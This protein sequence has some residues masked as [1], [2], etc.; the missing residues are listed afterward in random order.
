MAF[1]SIR[2]NRDC[3]QVIPNRTL[4]VLKN[5]LRRYR[6]LISAGAA[7]PQL[8]GREGINLET[9][10]FWAIRFTMIVAPSDRDELG[11][12]FLIRHARNGAQRERPCCCGEEEVLRHHQIRCVKSSNLLIAVFHVD[13]DIIGYDDFSHRMI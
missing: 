10:A 5:G 4:A 3:Q 6:E 8:A 7:F 1:G 2:K 9:P 11:V 12:R 13:A